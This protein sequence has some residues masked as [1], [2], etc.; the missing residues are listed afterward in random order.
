M[1]SRG[2]RPAFDALYR[3]HVDWVYR[4]LSRL[5]GLDPERDDLVQQVF[6]EAYRA[7]PRFRGESSFST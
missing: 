2:D 4:R 5:V 7:L 1:A 3:S 6:V